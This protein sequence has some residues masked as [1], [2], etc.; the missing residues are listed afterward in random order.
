MQ[1]VTFEQEILP[2]RIKVDSGSE[3]VSKVLDK[4]TYENKVELD[5]SIPR[6]PSDNPFIES[7]NGSFRDESL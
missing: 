6:K 4:W 1:S 2:K 7:F 5:F 3:F